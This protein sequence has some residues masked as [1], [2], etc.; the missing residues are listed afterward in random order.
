MTHSPCARP[1][2]RRT[3]SAA[4]CRITRHGWPFRRQP[5]RGVLGK[6]TTVPSLILSG[7]CQRLKIGYLADPELLIPRGKTIFKDQNQRV[8]GIA[9][10]QVRLETLCAIGKHKHR[11]CA[12]RSFPNRRQRMNARH[13]RSSTN[14][15]LFIVRHRDCCHPDN[16]PAPRPCR[17][18]AQLGKRRSLKPVNL[19]LPPWN[20]ENTVSS[21]PHLPA[22][23]F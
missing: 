3:Y 2:A 13:H 23:T 22:H 8:V 21:G 19:C 11:R 16:L 5:V 7:F 9:A 12:L 20:P 17:P 10:H 4:N 18:D 6:D 1:A 15:C 14:L